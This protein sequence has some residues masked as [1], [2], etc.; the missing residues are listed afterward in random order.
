MLS[1]SVLGG[2]DLAIGGQRAELRSRK[3]QA[4]LA[5]LLLNPMPSDTRERL[6]GLLWSE[7]AEEKARASL[8]QVLHGLRETFESLGFAGL[9]LD[10]EAVRLDRDAI[11]FD[12]G[13][14]LADLSRGAVPEI[15]TAMEQPHEALLAGFD[16]L[17]PGFDVWLTIHRR[18]IRERF[19]HSLFALAEGD[20]GQETTIRAATALMNI[21]PTNEVACRTLMRARA[22]RGELSAGLKVYRKLWDHLADEYDMEPSPE[23]QALAV[24]LKSAPPAVLTRSEAIVLPG[25]GEP[26]PRDPRGEASAQYAIVVAPFDA[27]GVNTEFGYLISGLRQELIAKLV[28]F[29]EWAIID[30]RHVQTDAMQSFAAR[31]PGHIWLDALIFEAGGQIRIS[32]T[33]R[34]HDDANV[35]WSDS[36]NFGLD[37]WFKIE[38]E[39]LSRMAAT[40]NIHVS[41]ARLIASSGAP[42]V[43]LAVYDRWLRGQSIIMNW[44]PER[45]QA[46]GIYRQILAEAPY[47][48]PAHSSLAQLENMEHLALPGTFRTSEREAAGLDH[49][50]HAVRYDPFDSRAHLALGWASA[51]NRQFDQAY[52]AFTMALE[53]NENDPWTINS[54]ALGCAYCGDIDHAKATLE[55]ALTWGLKPTAFHAAYQGAI[56]FMAGDYPAALQAYEQAGDI[57]GDLAAW[58]AATL[59]HLGRTEEARQTMQHFKAHA[60]ARWSGTEEATEERLAAWLLHAFPIRARNVWERLREGVVLAGLAV[61]REDEIP[62]RP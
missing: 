56:R 36:F 15:L 12:V 40:L 6:C 18:L 58:K 27:R 8:R 11:A 42:D 38:R 25:G 47:F 62:R 1:I 32:I 43:S 50:R 13:A 9:Q 44:K 31:W 22:A 26:D 53:L 28:R 24:E 59:A 33:V 4:L 51:M 3:A 39:L 10:R 54:A 35:I 48:S 16:G 37:N 45:D 34:R 61:P 21:D 46:R 2:F 57:I 30:G 19:E 41:T 20:V 14:V 17:D 52:A 7:F 5:Y 23:T 29:R 49:A 55:K 60:R